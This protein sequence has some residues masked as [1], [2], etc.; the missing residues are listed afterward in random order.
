[1]SCECPG[2]VIG[3]RNRLKIDR[4]KACGFDSH[5]GHWELFEKIQCVEYVCIRP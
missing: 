4:R 1:M 2:G 3:S 5:P